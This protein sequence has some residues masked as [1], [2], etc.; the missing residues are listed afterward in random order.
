MFWLHSSEEHG[1]D[2]GVVATEAQLAG[3][4]ANEMQSEMHGAVLTGVQIQERKLIVAN[5]E[6]RYFKTASYDFCLGS[7][8]IRCGRQGRERIFLDEKNPEV[9][10]GSFET[11]IFST[12][13]H[14]QTPKDVVGKFGLKIRLALRG[15]ILQVGPQIEPRY[16]GPL[17]GMILNTSGEPVTLEWKQP[18]LVSEFL[19]TLSAPTS[20]SEKV[21]KSLA[22]FL[23]DQG[24]DLEQLNHLNAVQQLRE[25]FSAYQVAHG[26][27]MRARKYTG[28]K[29]NQTIAIVLMG[30]TLLV[31]LYAVFQERINPVITSV[32]HAVFQT[33]PK[34]EAIH[35][36]TEALISTNR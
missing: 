19:K 18:F 4:S 8:V 23:R 1:R 36:H 29:R 26:N 6:E 32:W 33:H 27:K 25:D 7:D 3:A 5:G 16:K 20:K 11:M 12:Y 30:L 9:E 28:S 35:G 13:E 24:V 10:I 14:V 22:E 15:L 21:I 17:F 31:S 34:R 2:Q